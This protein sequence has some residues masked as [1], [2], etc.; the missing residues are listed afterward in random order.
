MRL[1][2]IL[3][4]FFA[5]CGTFRPAL[6]SPDEGGPAWT[7]VVSEHFVVRTD[8]PPDE[9][10]RRTTEF[11][12]SYAL[13]SDIAFRST[14]P[15]SDRVEVVLF[16]RNSDFHELTRSPMIMGFATTLDYDERP[17]LV[18]T[19]H[20]DEEGRRVFQHELTHRFVGYFM[21]SAP[22]WLNEGM[23]EYYSSARVS[24]DTAVIG[25]S[26][27][28]TVTT[29]FRRGPEVGLSELSS[30]TKLICR[31]PG[32]WVHDSANSPAS[33]G[34]LRQGHGATLTSG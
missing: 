4:G 2:L 5:G 32:S 20:F 14:N 11:E 7:E 1:V 31:S 28:I 23:A 15:P 27:G 17:V 3:L 30:A 12:A 34:H 10:Q 18:M 9:A 6:T 16:E 26:P 8:L 13:L 33:W 19:A 22:I 24:G 29:S 25:E 21:P